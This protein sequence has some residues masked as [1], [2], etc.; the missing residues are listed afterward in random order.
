MLVT[1]VIHVQR[2]NQATLRMSHNHKRNAFRLF[3]IVHCNFL[4]EF[5]SNIKFSVKLLDI[6]HVATRFAIHI[7]TSAI[8]QINRKERK[9][10]GI[11]LF[12]KFLLEEVIV[13][14][15]HVQ[16]NTA[17]AY[18]VLRIRTRRTPERILNE[19]RAENFLAIGA[20]LYRVDFK[21]LAEFH[22]HLHFRQG[23]F[24]NIGVHINFGRTIQHHIVQ[25]FGIRKIHINRRCDKEKHQRN[26]H[27]D[28]FNF[29]HGYIILKLATLGHYDRSCI[30]SFA[31]CDGFK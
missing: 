5:Y 8:V 4:A 9:A 23:L 22:V 21:R 29:F 24:N 6:T 11:S 27:D 31:T 17:Q 16:N 2:R 7:R 13:V 14:A 15:M 1:A 28:Y 12:G 25:C 30:T 26:N 10:R 3:V 18:I 19:R 20:R